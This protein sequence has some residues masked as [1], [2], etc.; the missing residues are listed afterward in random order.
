MKKKIMFITT[1]AVI[2]AL[3]IAGTAFA[4]NGNESGETLEKTDG[5]GYGRSAERETGQRFAVQADQYETEEEFHAAVLAQKLTII[6][7]KV[8]DGSLAPEA[9]ETIRTHLTECDGTC[10]TEGEN[11]NKPEDGW[12]IFGNSG[13]DGQGFMGSGNKGTGTRAADCD[14]DGEPI[15]DGSGSENGQGYRGGNNN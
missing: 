10:E 15:L 9:A 3:A 6:D 13:Q 7:A 8:L 14:E 2:I 12:G 5:I 4:G 1:V 11:P